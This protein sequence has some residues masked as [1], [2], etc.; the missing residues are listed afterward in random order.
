[1]RTKTFV[2]KVGTVINR[3][4]FF[5]FF[6]N[7]TYLSKR[8]LLCKKFVITVSNC[9]GQDIAH[10]PTIPYSFMSY[11]A[12][13]PVSYRPKISTNETALRYWKWRGVLR[14]NLLLVWL[15]IFELWPMF[16]PKLII[17][18]GVKYWMGEIVV[19]VKLCSRP[20]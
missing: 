16:R 20:L 11:T 9:H 1:M 15:L 17:V 4:I 6:Y 7:P 18:T 12:A 10:K 3:G 14:I 13:L 19:G 5:W 8:L 2:D